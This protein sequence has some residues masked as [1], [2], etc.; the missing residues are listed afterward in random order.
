MLKANKFAFEHMNL[1]KYKFE[2]SSDNK[3]SILLKKLNLSK[4][5]QKN[6]A[7]IKGPFSDIMMITIS[8]THCL[9][10]PYKTY[11]RHNR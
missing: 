5:C 9:N 3:P 10:F 2:E 6:L 8:L 1:S 4:I 7:P 11:S